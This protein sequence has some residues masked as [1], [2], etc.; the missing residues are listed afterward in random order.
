MSLPYVKGVTEAIARRMRT[1]GVNVHSKPTNTI[2]SMLVH[3]KDRTSKMNRSGVVYKINCGDCPSSYVGETG[4]SLGKRVEE[5]AG[6][7]SAV[8]THMDNEGH[9]FNSD[10]VEI[11]AIETD[12]FKRGVKE[13]IHIKEQNPTLNQDRG[14]HTLPSVYSSILNSQ[15][16]N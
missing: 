9:T 6:K 12:W 1:A 3:P 8:A 16:R 4:R 13:S 15:N 10:S 2:R 7:T 5:H 14:R 11:M